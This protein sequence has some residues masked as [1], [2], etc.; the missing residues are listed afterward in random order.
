MAISRSGGGANRSAQPDAAPVTYSTAFPLTENPISQGGIF[1]TGA[2]DGLDWTDIQTTPGKMIASAFDPAVGGVM[3]GVAQLKRTY[4]ACLGKQYSQG[5]IFIAGGY[6]PTS[7]ETE[8]FCNLTI[9]AH[10]I[11][12]YELYLS[13]EG[14]HTLVRWNGAFNDFTPLASNNVSTFTAPVDGDVIR[15]EHLLDGTL[16]CYQNGVLRTTANDTTYFSGNPG[17]GNNPASGG[18]AVLASYGLKS[19]TCGSL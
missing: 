17:F 12:G 3:D 2:T 4:L 8:V 15:I 19:W 6:H 10:S 14:N 5:A 7:H 9:T 13:T 11:T 1:L 16:N 18:G